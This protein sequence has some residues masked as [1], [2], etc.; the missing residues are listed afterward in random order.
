MTLNDV[1]IL[2]RAGF[3]R[4]DIIAITRVNSVTP[5]APATPAPAPATPAPAPAAPAPAPAT[6]APAPAAPAPAP[7]APATPTPAPADWMVQMEQMLQRHSIHQAEQPAP[8]S[9][10]D[11]LAAIINPPLKGD[12][13]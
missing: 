7:A 2:A 8:P 13:N 10:D 1:I 4:D 11:I 3:T 6:P 12:G 5:A 9:D